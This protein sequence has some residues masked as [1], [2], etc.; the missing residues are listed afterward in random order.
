MEFF[1]PP[2]NAS[3]EKGNGRIFI[4]SLSSSLWCRERKKFAC[5]FPRWAPFFFVS[6]LP[7]L[8]SVLG[9]EEEKGEEEFKITN[10]LSFPHKGSR[11]VRFHAN[12]AKNVQLQWPLFC[13]KPLILEKFLKNY[14]KNYDWQLTLYNEH[15]RSRVRTFA[16]STP[17]HCNF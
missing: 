17:K 6:L 16:F 14:F 1:P 12:K 3:A 4:Y 8:F 5:S 15:P 9:I 13:K 2:P 11:E 7:P 10:C